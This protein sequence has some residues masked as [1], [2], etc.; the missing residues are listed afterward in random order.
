MTTVFISLIIIGLAS[1]LHGITGM[2]FP[3]IATPALAASLPLPQVIA[4]LAIPTFILNALVVFKK[5]ANQKTTNHTTNI[6]LLKRYWLLALTSVIGSIIGVKL[7]FILPLAYLSL[8]MAAVILYYAT[9]GLLALYHII[10][11]ISVP[12]GKISMASFGFLSGL[13]GGATN[14]MSPI[15]LMYL[16]SKT[17][18]KSEIAKASNLC[19]LLAKIVQIV[20]LWHQ[21]ANFDQKAWVLL[22]VIVAFSM[23][24]LIFGTQLR[25]RISQ[26]LFKQLIYIILLIIGIKVGWSGLTAL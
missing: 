16:L 18:D 6:A 17:Q 25:H 11:P 26:N 1:I 12:T 5:E 7:L 14:A 2:G 22:V 23:L 24:G 9:Q 21:F 15:L 10:K 13:I 3:L 20:L 19:Y 4:L 8:I